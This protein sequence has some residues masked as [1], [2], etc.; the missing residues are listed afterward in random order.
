MY[1]TKEKKMK[2]KIY[3]LLGVPQGESLRASNAYT[4]LDQKEI[5]NGE[6]DYDNPNFIFRPLS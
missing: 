3:E 2:E 4:V 1:L 6:W 5:K